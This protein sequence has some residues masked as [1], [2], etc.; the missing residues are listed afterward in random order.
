MPRWPLLDEDELADDLDGPLDPGRRGIKGLIV[1][2]VVAALVAVA[3]AIWTRPREEPLAPPTPVAGSSVAPS[4]AQ[5]AAVAEVTVYVSGKVKRPG[6]I[7]LPLGS[8]VVDAI[9]AAGG[10]RQ[11]A[12]PGGL[13]LARR[14]IDGEQIAVGEPGVAAPPPGVTESGVVSLN[15]AT[16]DQLDR[17]PG[18]GEVLAQRIVEY[19][20]TNGGF[21]SI[22][23]L[24]EVEGIGEAK[25]ADLKDQVTL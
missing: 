3:I 25:F 18:V 17:L 16:V 21:Q 19:R 10:L 24:R 22:E 1:V 9:M 2:G 11:G 14:V 4:P 20:D 5:S 15:T 8:R 7:A 23:Q 13:N 6:V 12:Q